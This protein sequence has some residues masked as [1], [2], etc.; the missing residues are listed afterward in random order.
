MKTILKN[1]FLASMF[2][3]IV[4][5]AVPQ[6][7][8]GALGLD[9]PLTAKTI[10][11]NG[12]LRVSIS[13]KVNEDARKLWAQKLEKLT[14]NAGK[15]TSLTSK[16]TLR[17]ICIGK[18]PDGKVTTGE[19]TCTANLKEYGDYQFQL[20]IEGSIFGTDSGDITGLGQKF[21][22]REID[23][24]IGS[25][26]QDLAH[27]I[28]ESG[29]SPVLTISGTLPPADLRAANP[30]YIHYGEIANKDPFLLKEQKK[31]TCTLDINKTPD[32][33]LNSQQTAC[34][35]GKDGAFKVRVNYNFATSSQAYFYIHGGPYNKVFTN[36]I[37][38]SAPVLTP[39]SYTLSSVEVS[40]TNAT[41]TIH[42][43]NL[44]LATNYTIEV[45]NVVQ[46]GSTN[47]YSCISSTPTITSSTLK[48]QPS[49]ATTPSV[50]KN[51]FDIKNP[52]LYCVRL[53]KENPDYPSPGE[54]VVEYFQEPNGG[55]FSVGGVQ[56][57]NNVTL[58]KGANQYGCDSPDDNSAYCLLA[59]L[60][61]I[62]NEQGLVDTKDLGG[63]VN[64]LI[65][66][67]IGLTAVLSV[68]MLVVG[69]IQYMSTTAV[70]GKQAARDRIQNAIL[71]ILLAV[72]SYAILNT[73]N[74]NLVNLQFYTP[75]EEIPFEPGDE[76]VEYSGLSINRGTLD[77]L[78]GITVPTGTAK[79][80]ATKVL[81]LSNASKITLLSTNVIRDTADIN[82]SSA[83]QN[84][85]DTADGKAGWTSHRAHGGA[86]Q[87]SIHE[88]IFKALILMS[89]TSK[90]QVNEILGGKHS[91]SSTHYLGKGLDIQ[92]SQSATNVN[93]A[94]MNACRAAGANP[95]KI[96]GPCG[97]D[98]NSD[99]TYSTCRTTGY[100]TN[101][102]HK[103]HIHCGW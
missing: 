26:V 41:V 72:G 43:F 67:I 4:F 77:D 25:D 13:G 69:G 93:R 99:G 32:E 33:I 5:L 102:D 91:E 35:I 81:E 85:K 47:V 61:E 86:R 54:P 59:P 45:G 29:S 76:G 87:V 2:G 18:S 1:V 94:L 46:V 48:S 100:A 56:I 12:V 50:I 62:G 22:V 60:P 8:F 95:D 53:F 24:V 39:T 3:A 78:S 34:G 70:G 21:T 38:F 20:F 90:I 96:Y 79:E 27:S 84:V 11:E 30:V 6:T 51:T 44:R 31:S 97:S 92:A 74:P 52:G 101:S 73:I 68:L 82:R 19:F 15:I 64:G 49:T 23:S 42:A 14:I 16:P 83:L 37:E 88:G 58:N 65:R 75:G 7:T 63:Y 98:Y 28:D 103:T 66:L 80:L 55:I 40:G 9:G 89:D 36:L 17:E 10:R 57:P 71:G